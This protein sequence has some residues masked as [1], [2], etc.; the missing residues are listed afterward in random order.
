LDVTAAAISPLLG[1]PDLR[2]P[3][4]RLALLVISSNRGLAGGY[5]SA[6]LRAASVFI[7]VQ[8]R[9]GN[10]IDL[11]V[12][13][14]KGVSYFRFRNRPILRGHE[15]PGDM[16][17]TA[18]FASAI[19]FFIQQFCSGEVD[20]VSLAYTPF[21]RQCAQRPEV[22]RLLPMELA[23]APKRAMPTDAGARQLPSGRGPNVDYSP[24]A[25]AILDELL[26]R[27][28]R[29]E[30]R[31][32]FLDAVTSEN[33]ARQVAMKRATD[34]AQK[35]I[36]RLTMQYNRARQSQITTELCEIMAGANATSRAE[37]H[38]RRPAWRPSV[39][40]ETPAE[41]TAAWPSQPRPRRPRSTLRPRS[42]GW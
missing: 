15:D 16:P 22:M 18:Q 12:V 5:N 30:F 34:N 41:E 17:N 36:K 37:R 24:G 8:E 14:R 40:P 32:C 33:F 1:A 19:D 23:A 39:P 13:G 3:A 42:K 27:L 9:E 21:Q 38:T 25:Q 20:G 6:V 7:D 11:Y 29:A 26:P 10:A 2:K 28:I 4:N 35:L 31:Q